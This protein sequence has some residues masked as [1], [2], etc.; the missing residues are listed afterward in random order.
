MFDNFKWVENK[1]AADRFLKVWKNVEETVKHWS[2]MPKSKQPTSKSYLTV[3]QA[4]SDPLTTAKMSFFSLLLD[5]SSR[6]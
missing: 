1:K 6:F 5:W 3:K 2:K 4:I